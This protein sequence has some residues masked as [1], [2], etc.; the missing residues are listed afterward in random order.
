MSTPTAR[1][2]QPQSELGIALHRLPVQLRMLVRLMGEAPAF[3]LVQALGGTPF[4]VPKSVHSPQFERLVA[5]CGCP[6][7]GAALVAEMPGET[8]QLPKYDGVAR[9]LRHQRVVELRGKGVRLAQIALTTGYTVR[10]VI[11]ILNRAG[12][13]AGVPPE[14]D[15]A[16]FD[17]FGAEPELEGHPH[18]A[19]GPSKAPAGV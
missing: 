5:A 9:Q 17:L 11:Y 1:S 13:D 16:Q 2:L 14:D 4:T 8:L 7:A 18:P 15:A 10:G 19:P 6:K 3:R 12:F